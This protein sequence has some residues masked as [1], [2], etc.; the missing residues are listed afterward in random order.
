MSA[1]KT[2]RQSQAEY[3]ASH[4]HEL[5]QAEFPADAEHQEDDTEFGDETDRVRPDDGTDKKMAP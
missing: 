2:N 1:T 4:H 3:H 5:G